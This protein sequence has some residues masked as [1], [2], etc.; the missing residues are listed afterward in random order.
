MSLNINI[1]ALF[2]LLIHILSLIFYNLNVENKSI[3]LLTHLML[4]D[5]GKKMRKIKI[6]G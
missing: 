1:H 5:K 2:L 4:D 3:I 6:I